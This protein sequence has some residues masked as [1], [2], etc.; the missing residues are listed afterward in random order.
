MLAKMPM[1]A[2]ILAAVL[3]LAAL[4]LSGYGLYEWSQKNKVPGAFISADSGAPGFPMYKRVPIPGTAFEWYSV[5]PSANIYETA[6]I[7]KSLGVGLA[8]K[9]NIPG[10]EL[11]AALGPRWAAETADG[12]LVYGVGTVRGILLNPKANPPSLVHILDYY[13]RERSVPEDNN[14]QVGLIKGNPAT[15][16]QIPVF[17]SYRENNYVFVTRDGRLLALNPSTRYLTKVDPK[18]YDGSFV[19]YVF[20]VTGMADDSVALSIGGSIMQANADSRLYFPTSAYDGF[21]EVVLASA[22]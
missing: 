16:M 14:P 7:A 19:D 8:M 15:L 6:K 10:V 5:A 1:G 4:A 9:K 2:K 21:I 13:N 22:E 11:T 3:V 17:S 12:T 20:T 18:H